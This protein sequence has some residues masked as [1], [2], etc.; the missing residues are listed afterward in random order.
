MAFLLFMACKVSQFFLETTVRK[1]K[2]QENK[3]RKDKKQIIGVM[4]NKKKA[5]YLSGVKRYT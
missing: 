5:K 2:D 4:I 3:S 1:A